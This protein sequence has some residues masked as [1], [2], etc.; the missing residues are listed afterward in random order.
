LLARVLTARV[1]TML[2]CISGKQFPFVANGGVTHV[3]A[4]ILPATGVPT[5]DPTPQKNKTA[6]N[7]SDRRSGPKRSI[8]ITGS[9]HVYTPVQCT[10]RTGETIKRMYCTCKLSSSQN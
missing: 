2:Y 8:S 3:R 9:M 6:P 4:F 5:A 1:L 10:H 7:E